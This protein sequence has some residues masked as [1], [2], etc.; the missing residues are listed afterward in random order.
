MNLSKKTL[1][2]SSIISVIMVS[3][4]VGYFI[5]MLPSLYVSYMQDRNYDSIVEL[6]EGYMESGSYENLEVKNPTGTIT[7]EIPVSGNYFYIVSK[8]FRITVDVKEQKLQ[9]LLAKLRYYAKHTD[10]I[11]NINQED[12]NLAAIKDELL[13]NQ[14]SLNNLPLSFEIETF[15]NE[16]VF[17]EESSKIHIESEDLVIYESNVTDGH[18]Y[19]TSYLAMGLTDSAIDITFLPIMTP[20]MEEIRPVI[21]Q[22]LPMIV[23]IALLLVLVSSQVFSKLI[24]NPVIRLANHAEYMK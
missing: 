24:I 14:E 5:F 20:R 11:K 22:S 13:G 2:Y 9:E 16:N 8:F 3:L 17:R 7:I 18:N 21:L 19:Y 15:N 12:F 23:A 6:Q 1:L 4:I 10:Q